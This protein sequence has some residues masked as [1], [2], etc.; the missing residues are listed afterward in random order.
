MVDRDFAPRAKVTT[1]IKDLETILATADEVGL[2][3]PLTH[4]ARE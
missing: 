4:H 1:Q 2:D 3:L